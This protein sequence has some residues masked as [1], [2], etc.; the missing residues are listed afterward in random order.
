MGCN[1]PI[2]TGSDLYGQWL[3]GLHMPAGLLL[4]PGVW[5]PVESRSGVGWRCLAG[6]GGDEM[7]FFHFFCVSRFGKVA[8]LRAFVYCWPSLRV[9]LQKILIWRNSAFSVRFSPVPIFCHIFGN[10]LH[11]SRTIMFPNLLKSCF[12]DFFSTP[13]PSKMHK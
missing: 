2:M 13:G 10:K 6:N 8:V 7:C 4:C 5:C 9:L 11:I 3:E 1:G 12:F